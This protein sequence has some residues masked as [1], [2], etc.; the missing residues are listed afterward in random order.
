[1]YEYIAVV[2]NVHDADS[3]R[4]DVDLGFGVWIS[5]IPFRL[6]GIQ[7]WEVGKEGGRAARDAARAL[8]PVGGEVLIKTRRDDREKYGR[9]LATVLCEAGDVA[10]ALVAGGHAVWWDGTGPRPERTESAIL[11]VRQA[12][13]LPTDTQDDFALAK[14]QPPV[15]EGRGRFPFARRWPAQPVREEN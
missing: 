10:T 1:M 6:L 5:N 14:G 12:V 9:Y 7:G 11:P 4:A 15:F 2:K 3:F 13:V 8:M